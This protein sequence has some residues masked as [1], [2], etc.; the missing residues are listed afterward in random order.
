MRRYD[1]FNTRRGLRSGLSRHRHIR[2]GYVQFLALQVQQP[3][4]DGRQQRVVRAPQVA[5]LQNVRRELDGRGGRPARALSRGCSRDGSRRRPRRRVLVPVL[6]P[7]ILGGRG[8]SRCGHSRAAR[9][10][11]PRRRRRR[12]LGRLPLPLLLLRQHLHE[13]VRLH[14]RRRDAVQRLPLP[15]LRGPRPLLRRVEFRVEP[16]QFT[17]R[18]VDLG[19]EPVLRRVHASNLGP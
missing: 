6:D 2:E 14:R 19:Q 17:R 3:R 11:F 4:L 9:A 5:S 15:L 18:G 1:F 8:R 12:R 7:G 16:L 10:P 13:P